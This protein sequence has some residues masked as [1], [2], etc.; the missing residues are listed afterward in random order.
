M[1]TRGTR[2]D[3]PGA[4]A[5]ALFAVQGA[6]AATR[7]AATQGAPKQQPTVAASEATVSGFAR[8]FVT[9]HPIPDATI[10]AL[11]TGRELRTD[12][13]GRYSLTY[14]V[15]GRLTLQL[16]K[17]GFEPL[18]TETAVV[19]AG[20]LTGPHDNITFQALL[21]PEYKLF[22][23]AIGMRA[24]PGMCHVVT[25]I[26]AYNKTM[27]DDRQGEPGAHLSISPAASD[28]VFYFAIFK[29]RGPLANKTNPFVR[30]LQ[31]ASYDGGAI[32]ANLPPRED[33]YTLTAVK[34]GVR[35]SAA[36]IWCRPGSLINVSPPRGP[37]VQR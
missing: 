17:D 9:G 26:A 10:V 20:G 34:E 7:P 22:Q 21:V 11:E 4:L 27:D 19:P 31:E 14:P 29:D 15:G 8:E 16:R 35:F 3:L 1:S 36:K 24:Q 18:Q 23:G 6:C 28:Q 32:V 30:T 13:D 12:R 2:T 5:L 37:T 33:L 25:T